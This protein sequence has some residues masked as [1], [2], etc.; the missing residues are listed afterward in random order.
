MYQDNKPKD[1]MLSVE[2]KDG[3]VNIKGKC[4][5]KDFKKHIE[6]LKECGIDH[7]GGK[8]NGNK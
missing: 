6:L 5:A 1:E 7:V 3:E 2:L 8:R 4:K